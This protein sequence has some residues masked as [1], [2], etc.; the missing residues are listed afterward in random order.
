[1]EGEGRGPLRREREDSERGITKIRKRGKEGEVG[2]AGVSC[3]VKQ[4]VGS[5]HQYL[6][7]R[8]TRVGSAISRYRGRLLPPGTPGGQ[9]ADW[10]QQRVLAPY[11]KPCM[12][13]HSRVMGRGASYLW[14]A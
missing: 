6:R 4:Q 7:R 1:M 10:M 3:F 12:A 14:R 5:R 11:G 8:M 13:R 9:V 2:R